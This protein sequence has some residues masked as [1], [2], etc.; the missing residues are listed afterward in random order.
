MGRQFWIAALAV[1]LVSQISIAKEV[2]VKS[3]AQDDR[4]LYPPGKWSFDFGVGAFKNGSK[5]SGFP[6][7]ELE[8][9]IVPG[10][11]ASVFGEFV[12][13]KMFG[14]NES[15]ATQ[16][17]LGMGLHYYSKRFFRGFTAALYAREKFTREVQDRY[18]KAFSLMP[19]V[20]WR[21]RNEEY[22]AS[23]SAQVGLEKTF[24]SNVEVTPVALLSIGVD[25][26][27]SSVFY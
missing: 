23:F 15:D 3:W 18:S 9:L 16:F 24:I 8:T 27:P 10:M 2:Q 20:G 22:H 14:G 11:T 1:V 19:L 4:F 21:W 17:A 6:H 25:F 26:D 5:T 13:K 7:F 12:A